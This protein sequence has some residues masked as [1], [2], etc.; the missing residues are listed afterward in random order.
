LYAYGRGTTDYSAFVIFQNGAK[1]HGGNTVSD[2]VFAA[3]IGLSVFYSRAEHAAQ[4]GVRM[5]REQS[6][7][8]D[9]SATIGN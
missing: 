2:F 5:G 7:I 9:E 4:H 1:H 3:F 6:W 8:D